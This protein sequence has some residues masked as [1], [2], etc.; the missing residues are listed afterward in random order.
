M[1]LHDGRDGRSDDGSTAQIA[2][3]LNAPVVLVLD[4]RALAR[5]AAAMIHGYKTF[6]PQVRLAGVVLNRV[7]GAAHAEWIREAL[8]T[9]P[10]TADVVVLGYLPPDRRV[11]VCE[12]T[13]GLVPPA[14]GGASGESEGDSAGGGR[15][16]ALERLFDEHVDIAALREIAAGSDELPLSPPR[17][18]KL[19]GLTRAKVRGAL[20]RR[21]PVRIAV[22][23]DAAFCFVYD[24]NLTMLQAAGATLVFFSPLADAALPEDADAVYLIGGYPE[25]YARGLEA[26]S[27]MRAAVREFCEREGKFVWAECGGLMYLAEML[28]RRPGDAPAV[29]DSTTGEAPAVGNGGPAGETGDVQ[30]PQAEEGELAHEMCGVLPFDVTMTPRMSMGYCVAALREPTARLLRLPLG[31]SFRC[32][33][34]HFSEATV[35]GEPAV[36]VNPETGGGAGISTLRESDH[37]F[38]VEMQVPGALS[39]PEGALL[40]GG[41]VAT[42]CHFH[43]GAD[44]RLAPAFV[45]A[46]RRGQR[47]VSLVPSGTEIVALILGE[48]EAAVRL[49]G[50][51]EYCDFPAGLV[52]RLPVI[53]RAVVPLDEGMSGAEVDAALKQAREAGLEEAHVLD[54]AWLDTHRPGIVLTQDTCRS[55]DAAEGTVLGALEAAGLSGERALTLAPV[56]VSEMLESVQRV[57]EALGEADAAAALVDTLSARLSFIQNAVAPVTALARPRVLGLES[58]CPLVASGQWLLDVRIRAGGVDALGGVVGCAP[59]VVTWDEVEGCNAEVIIICCCGRTADG[60][61]AEVE[62]HLLTRPAIWKL[63]AL[64]ARPPRV[65]VT[66]HEHFS[67]PGPRLVDGIETIATLLH[68]ELL[69]VQ[70]VSEY[71]AGVLRLV[72]DDEGRENQLGNALPTAWYFEDTGKKKSEVDSPLLP[73]AQPS[74][75][76]GET[77]V[78]S[79]TPP[80]RSAATLVLADSGSLMLFGGECSI[81]VRREERGMGDVWALN[82]PKDGKW[83]PSSCPDAEWLGPWDCGATANE[84]VPTPRANHAAVACGD[85][86]LVFG[87]WSNYNEPLS[88]PELLHLDTRCWT[89]CSTTNPPPPPRGNPSLVYSSNRHLAIAYGGWNKVARLDDVWCLDMESWTWY[90]AAVSKT[91]DVQP[92]PRTDHTALLWRASSTSE[93][94]L[95]FGGSTKS[96]ASDELW[97]LDCSSGAPDEWRWTNETSVCSADDSSS[98][99]VPWPASRTSHA[100][101]IVGSGSSARLIVVGGQDGR[102]GTGAASIVADAWILS[103]LGSAS[104]RWTQLDCW[105]G[106]YPLQRC[107]HSLAVVGDKLVV[108][109][110]GYDGVRTLDA[111]HSVFCAPLPEADGDRSEGR[112]EIVDIESSRRRQ[113]E[114]WAAERPV[115]EAELDED[116][117]KRVALSTLPLALSKALHRFALKSSPPRDT[118]IDPESGYSVFTQAYL[119]RRPC[120]GNECRHCPWSHVNVPRKAN[121]K[122]AWEAEDVDDDAVLS[123]LEW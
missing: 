44:T 83:V 119:K 112:P 105:R 64:R 25:W 57:G 26:N 33:Q 89:H 4:A 11:A 106:T 101:A 12:R 10:S 53:S 54:V 5:S 16:E 55:C 92:E 14:A 60:A 15:L 121:G 29:S 9:A 48:K 39:A 42:Y 72:V 111:H 8:R 41:T 3:W 95:V 50:V 116:D 30:Q 98:P 32:Q 100:A 17:S 20:V 58:L 90:R 69:P 93:K 71:T 66:S 99:L 13:L 28:H 108:L 110:G 85:H 113:Q 117:L 81:D 34:Y 97:S 67:R 46:A 2:K 65:Y 115:T 91:I 45:G 27:G 84:S 104:R 51:S 123:G 103:P 19:A 79:A 63:P 77:F 40:H 43:F 38:D 23:R 61:V 86:M 74:S 68:P 94:M 36:V 87:G 80:V 22:A 122:G 70:L 107:R 75:P 21:P 76:L 7:A 120:C 114:R 82:A 78:D 49:I 31:A 56:T 24:D 37:A 18:P 59:R 35:G 109:Y 96:G 52:R 88:H 62:T 6:D 47:V 1:G 118:Y 102:L 73:V